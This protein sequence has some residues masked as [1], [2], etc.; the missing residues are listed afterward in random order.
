MDTPNEPDRD[1]RTDD[2]AVKAHATIYEQ[3]LNLPPETARLAAE[4]NVTTGE[5][6]PASNDVDAA[7]AAEA[8]ATEPGEKR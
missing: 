6:K 2:E 1:D 7:R 8:R 3:A 4:D 5:R